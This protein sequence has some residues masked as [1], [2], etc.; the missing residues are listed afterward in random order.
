MKFSTIILLGLIL[1]N[2]YT[3]SGQVRFECTGETLISVSDGKTT[4]LQWPR[5]PPFAPPHYGTFCC[6]DGSF[7]AIGFNAK[8]NYIYGVEEHT[9]N[10]L[11]IGRSDFV[12]IG[13]V[14]G[15]DTLY[16]NAGDCT[17]E[18]LYM[19]YDHKLQKMLVFDVVDTFKLLRQVDLFWDSKS[20]NE[21]KF[22]AQI[23]DFAFDPNDPKTAYSYQGRFDQLGPT[24]TQGS[25]LKIN[26]NLDDP[27]LG[28][29]TPMAK[30][31]DKVATHITGLAF[32]ARSQLSGFGSDLKGFNPPQNILFGIEAFQGRATSILARNPIYNVSDA[33]SCPYSLTFTNAGPVD[34]M[35]CNNDSKTFVVAFDNNSYVSI[36][37]V[38]LKDT[39]PSGTVIK[40]VSDTFGGTI[41]VGTGI[42]SNI[43]SISGLTIP[44]KQRFEIKIE[45]MSINAQDGPAYNRAY[46]HN[47]PAHFP[48]RLDS[49][50]PNSSTLGDA[51]GFYFTT[52]PIKNLTWR[53][54]SPTDCLK[55]DDG[56]ITFT[57][58]DLTPGQNYVVS[59]RNTKGW[60][61]YVETVKLDEQHSFTFDGL[62]PGEYQLFGIR[63][64]DADCNASLKD[65]LILLSAPN[66]LLD[67]QISSNSPVCEGDSLKLT[68]I[69]TPNGLINW[70]AENIFYADE[71][72]PIIANVD[73][74][75]TGTYEVTG[76]YGYCIQKKSLDV[77]I[78]Q[79]LNLEIDGATIY[80]VRDTLQLR[81]KHK[82]KFDSL[83]FNWIGPIDFYTVDSTI[84]F[85]ITSQDQM[86]Y[87]QVI[88]NNGACYDTVGLDIVVLPTPSLT[89]D[90]LVITNFCEPLQLLP[91]LEGGINNMVYEWTP[92]EGLECNDCPNPFV[93]PFVQSS[94]QLKVMNEYKCRDSATVEIFLDKKN[95]IIAPNILKPSSLLENQ[96]FRIYPNCVVNHLQSLDIYDRQGNLIFQ[97]QAV[98]QTDVLESWDGTALGQKVTPGVYIWS[99]KA[100]LVDGSIV[101][102]TGDITVL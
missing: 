18:G 8:D 36:E 17:P 96:L 99:A 71:A 55:A 43:L 50:N 79:Q 5:F 76:T 59:L 1:A 66:H 27:N 93:L 26:L 32:N 20:M 91:S 52:R 95:S 53:T 51:T 94:Y 42:G 9:N 81:V 68:S 98:N 34:G 45:I 44:A 39:F 11:R 28:M 23:F 54:V 7:D 40:A 22:N 84:T 31:D 101:Y 92:K 33:C 86:G 62:N 89:L 82:T 87:Y 25:M 72:N 83:K 2:L 102:L 69:L 88:S 46:L 70:A 4:N 73:T 10:I 16:V 12:R 13:K 29:V 97:T 75:K 21:G 65:T 15:I 67:L 90:E 35:Y 85:P 37:N 60:K 57:S 19:C 74:N 61:E 63:P 100:E 47:L 38:V 64:E 30:I 41:D 6:Y 24:N 80:C 49:D 48:V 58:T 77:V 3:L 56:K 14:L 78:D